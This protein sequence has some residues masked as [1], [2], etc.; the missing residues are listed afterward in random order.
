[1]SVYVDDLR[2]YGWR[3]GPSCHLWADDIDELHTFAARIGM[4]RSWFQDNTL[5]H[6]DLVKSRRDRAIQLGAVQLD[7]R[8]AVASWRAI[9]AASKVP[10]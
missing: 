4:K 6:Y 8:S 2:D 3:L 10:T 5:P 7:R 9:E 1:M